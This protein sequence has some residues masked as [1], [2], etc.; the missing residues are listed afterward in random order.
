MAPTAIDLAHLA[1]RA[2]ITVEEAASLLGVSRGVAYQ[3]I[4]QAEL[5][6]LRLGRRIL[7]PVPALLTLL[8]V[9]SDGVS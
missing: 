7:V 2:T 5:P 8:G 3:A 1:G 6:A 4:R 9:P